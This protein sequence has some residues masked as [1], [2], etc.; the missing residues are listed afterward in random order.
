MK[1]NKPTI[2]IEE[3]IGKLTK[4]KDFAAGIP[5]LNSSISQI[6]KYMKPGDAVTT[7]RKLNQKGGFDC[8]GCAWPD[9]DDDRSSL[10]EYCENG[11][12]AIAEEA[13]KKS[14]S[15]S[16]FKENSISELRKKSDFELGKLGRINQPY[17][18]ANGEDTFKP[19]DWKAALLHIS[20]KLKGLDHPDKAIFYTSGRTSNEAAYLYQLFVRKYGTNNLPDCSNMCHESSGVGLG[21]T[22]GIGKGSVTLLDIHQAEL[23]MIMGQNPG[24]N[25]PRMLSALEKCKQNGGKIISVNPL[26]EAGLVSFKHPQKVS[27]VLLGGTKITDI[28]CQV[29]INSDIYF[30]KAIMKLLIGYDEKNKHKI[31]D[32]NFINDK[33]DGW[34]ALKTS[35]EEIDINECSKACGISLEKLEKVA[36]LF[37][38]NE[39][40]IICWAMGLTQHLNGAYNIQE[41][42]NLLLMKGAIG[43]PGAGTC[44]VRGHSNVQGDRTMGI[45]HKPGNDFLNKLEERYHFKPPADHGVGVVDA[46]KTLYEEKAAVLFCMGGNLLNASPD[47]EY[48][49]EAMRKADLIVN[50]STKLNRTHLVSDHESII[51]PCRGRTEIDD[52]QFVSV[53]NSMGIVHKSEGVL[54]PFNKIIKSEV[55]IICELADILFTDASIP[56]LKFASNYDLIRDEIEA[57]IPGFD[58][59][60]KKVRQP[61]GFYLPNTAREQEFAT[62]NGKAHFTVNPLPACLLKE[63]EFAMM[64]I[65]SHDQFNTTIYGEDDRYRGIKGM[66]RIVFMNEEDMKNLGLKQFDEV[67]LYSYFNEE[68]RSALQF[69]VIPYDIPKK[70]I[71][72]YFPE[73]NSLIHINAYD[74]ISETPSSKFTKVLIKRT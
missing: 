51:L 39:K 60:N 65:R 50:V 8:P 13:T 32:Y 12:K 42:V 20:N 31:L 17:F 1:E 33:T 71:A 57:I 67:N 16:F 40:I 49:A 7:M 24:T 56:W 23:I 18:K 54:P 19:I 68:E 46:I 4:P 55:S 58:N 59:Y 3:K 38:T 11:V 64:T 26:K 22:L 5:A 47:T 44:P 66:R 35:L 62:D 36:K 48:T 34:E 37:A 21:K 61:A 63:N 73:A 43:K 6:A 2:P 69:K 14:L 10:G 53:E 70:N 9:P 27:K 72:T 41:V 28:Y 74:K 45:W 52:G 29:N 25:H 15:E 30:L